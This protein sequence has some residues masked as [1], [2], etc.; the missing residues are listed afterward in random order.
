M[1]SESRTFLLA[2]TDNG[3]SVDTKHKLYTTMVN[4]ASVYGDSVV[5]FGNKRCK[6]LFHETLRGRILKMIRAR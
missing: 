2:K 5:L 4:K 1:S 6:N 3:C